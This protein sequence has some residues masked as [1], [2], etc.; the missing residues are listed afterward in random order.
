MYIYPYNNSFT[1]LK[2]FFVFGMLLMNESL[3]FYPYDLA[4]P[5]TWIH[6]QIVHKTCIMAENLVTFY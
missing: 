4:I 3:L 5:H 6:V 1:Q 2:H